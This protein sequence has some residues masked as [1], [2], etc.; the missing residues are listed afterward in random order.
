M[1]RASHA[2][3]QA[4]DDELR[5]QPDERAR[6]DIIYDVVRRCYDTVKSI[7]AGGRLFVFDD[8]DDE[9]ERMS[10]AKVSDAALHHQGAM[11]G[12]GS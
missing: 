2:L 1:A 9:N 3:L 12:W 5:T 7:N 6:A 8:P 4:I 10:V 11:H